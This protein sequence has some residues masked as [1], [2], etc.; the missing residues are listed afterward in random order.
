MSSST[1]SLESITSNVIK[2]VIKTR[3]GN[4]DKEI[5]YIELI[6]MCC[7]M[8]EQISKLL[9]VSKSKKRLQSAE[10]LDLACDI[11]E[12][13]VDFLKD[14]SIPGKN[15]RILLHEDVVFI[16]GLTSEEM[17]KTVSGIVSVVN[18]ADSFGNLEGL[19]EISDS[20]VKTGCMCWKFWNKKKQE[21]KKQ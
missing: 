20:V 10:K 2:S 16:K 13:V 21:N 19:A 12:I 7:S 9:V 1:D 5:G 14:V 15:R 17:R 6:S 4:L 18:S 3:T 8:V 11:V